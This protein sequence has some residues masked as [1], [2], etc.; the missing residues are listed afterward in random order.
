MKQSHFDHMIQKGVVF[1]CKNYKSPGRLTWVFPKIMV[2]PNHPMFNRVFHYVH[3][4]FWGICPPIFGSTPTWLH[5]KDTDFFQG[6]SSEATSKSRCMDSKAFFLKKTT[7]L[8]GQ[9][10]T[11]M[12]LINS[13][14]RI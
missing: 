12:A 5:L 7:M 1:I 6:I 11:K 9:I 10:I 13:D 4:P 2:P 14:L 3:H 8:S